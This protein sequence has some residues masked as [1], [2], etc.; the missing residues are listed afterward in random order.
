MSKEH[1]KINLEEEDRQHE[2]KMKE[3]DDNL[4]KERF[5]HE[6]LRTRKALI[7]HEMENIER[8]IVTDKR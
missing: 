6:K 5:T 3:A 8:E 4:R 2:T 7:K 1:E